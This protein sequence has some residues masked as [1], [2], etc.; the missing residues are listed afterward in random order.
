[1]PDE[2]LETEEQVQVVRDVDGILPEG[3]DRRNFIAGT[4]GTLAMGSLAGCTGN[5][6]SGGTPTETSGDGEDNMIKNITWRQP[7]RRTMPW[8]PAFIGQHQGFY[9][10]AN[11]S[12]PNIEPGFGSPDTARRVGT[13]SAEVGHADTGSMTAGL[14]EGHEFT[15]VGASRQRTVLG[16]TWR[17]DRM[18]GPEDLEGKTV[19]Q[20]TP[21]ARATWPVV[22]SVL[23]LDPDAIST[24]YA[25][26][27][28]GVSQVVQGDADALWTSV[29]GA[30]PV[31]EAMQD[32]DTSVTSTPMNNWVDVAGY[33]FFVNTEWL[34][35]ESDSIE[36][37]SRLLSAY[38][39]TLKWV[40]VN[41]DEAIE[42]AFNEVNPGLAAQSEFV[43]EG[44]MKVNVCVILSE[45]IE[46]GGGIL[47]FDPEMMQTAMD[48]FGEALAED[49]STIPAYDDVVDKRPVDEAELSTFSSDEWNQAAEWAQP[50][51]DWFEA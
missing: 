50:V 45:F 30:M 5:G 10:D 14:A 1:M 4:V 13:G 35:N 47:D 11:I 12:N 6:D 49:P 48:T 33:G 42:L 9:T 24:T 21:F 46:N 44:M 25:S 23:D 27:G 16:L 7:W 37:L 34:E 51:W 15:I 22:P 31:H 20:G 40:A 8:T 36:Y 28:A 26:Q 29:N 19:V 32:S 43:M 2:S 39:R 38:S 17:E 18:S 3:I 41:P